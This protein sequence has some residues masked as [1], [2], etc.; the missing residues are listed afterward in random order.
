MDAR[1]RSLVKGL[2]PPLLVDMVRGGHR[3]VWEGVYAHLRDVP[4]HHASYDH[5]ERI[6]EMAAEVT[7]LLDQVKAGRKPWMRHEIFSTV[8]AIARSTV[9]RLRVVDF[10]GGPGIG[11]VKLLATLP[12]ATELNY[13][14]VDLPGIC[15]E[16]R[17]IFA[18]D[19]RIQFHTALAD[20]PVSPDITYV[21]SVLQYLEDYLAQLQALASLAAPW[22][23]LAR[24]ATGAIPTF[25]TSQRNLA[26]QVLP[27]W[28]VNRDELVHLL[29]GHKY[30]LILESVC[31]HEY[32]QSN[33]PVSHR[34]GRM[35][36]LLFACDGLIPARANPETF[37]SNVSR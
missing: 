29:G 9:G 26:G 33:F 11:F 30:R 2:A 35:R 28:F 25:A 5:G 22:L 23:L 16:G 36:N 20:I 12:T 37:S 18:G 1:L 24:T 3:F 31:E 14:I 8:A 17:R 34:V 6:R 4:S 19:D 7:G 10:G 32:N 13:H 15:E 21:N 27:Y